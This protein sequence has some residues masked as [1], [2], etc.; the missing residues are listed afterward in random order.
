MIKH[1]RS[2]TVMKVTLVTWWLI[3][4][5]SAFLVGYGIRSVAMHN[6]VQE[7]V[8]TSQQDVERAQEK[9]GEAR[10]KV[11]HLKARVEQLEEQGASD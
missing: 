9:A 8:L 6:A 11:E 4:P 1:L 7:V 2:A 3:V 5:L 10:L